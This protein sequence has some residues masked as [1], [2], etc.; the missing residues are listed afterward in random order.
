MSKNC[1]SQSYGGDKKNDKKDKFDM[2]KCFEVAYEAI[3]KATDNVMAAIKLE[4]P[5]K[6]V[7]TTRDLLTKWDTEIEKMLMCSI[8]AEYPNHKIIAEAKQNRHH[9]KGPKMTDEPT[10]FI[11]SIDGTRNFVHGFPYVGL[12]VAFFV[13]KQPEFGIM[14]N[15]LIDQ[16]FAS[17]RG[18]GTYMNAERIHVTKHS[19]LAEALVLHDLDTNMDQL[20]EALENISRVAQIAHAMRS[21]GSA[22]A[23]MCMIAR[24]LADAYYNF[25]CHCWDIAAP[26]LIVQEAGGVVLDPSLKPV[27]IMSRRVLV[28]ATPQ[29]AE[30]LSKQLVAIDISPKGEAACS[31][32]QED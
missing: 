32:T 3:R 8:K 28:A 11:D 4:Q 6:S 1:P 23:S 17:R 30:E 21:L 20:P 5:F 25:G 12:T 14:W 9:W 22:A 19:T 10:W 18:L 2:D 27:D 16:C 31:K 24:G 29:L 26:M 13:N 7:K 15:P